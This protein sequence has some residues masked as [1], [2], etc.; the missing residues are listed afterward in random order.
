ME[1]EQYTYMFEVEDRHW[2]YV[3]NHEH[4][5]SLLK[6]KGILKQGLRVLDAGCGTGKW[7][8]LLKSFGV[9]ETGAD[10]HQ[11]ALD[12]ARKRGTFNLVQADINNAGFADSQFELI[13]SFDVIC[14]TNIDDAKAV[15]NFHRWLQGTGYVLLTVPAY[16]FLHGKHDEVVHQDKRYTRKKLRRIFEQQGFEVLKITY[17]VSLLFPFALIKR[18]IDKLFGEKGKDHNEVKMPSPFI[19]ALFLFAMR[20]ENFALQFMPM[21]FGLSVLILARKK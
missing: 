10:Y 7:L 16:Q 18:I 20:V 6:R 12:L 13:T 2:W 4:F 3:G 9:I 15:A 1:P 21:P 17:T 14:N 19:N 11:N 8:E 5:L